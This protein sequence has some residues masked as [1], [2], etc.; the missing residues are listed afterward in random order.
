MKSYVRDQNMR[1]SLYKF[2][3]ASLVSTTSQFHTETGAGAAALKLKLMLGSQE[4]KFQNTS[5][6]P[7]STGIL[8]MNLLDEGDENE[9]TLRDEALLQLDYI[10]RTNEFQARFC[11]NYLFYLM[12][13]KDGQ[14]QKTGFIPFKDYWSNPNTPITDDQLIVNLLNGVGWRELKAGQKGRYGSF[15]NDPSVIHHCA[16]LNIQY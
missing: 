12:G 13:L 1:D 14:N 5:P 9:F 15:I 11:R 7:D 16:T 2:L 6:N 8:V 4:I 10:Y 3:E